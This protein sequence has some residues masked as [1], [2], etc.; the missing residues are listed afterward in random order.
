MEWI[1]ASKSPRRKQLLG[2]LIEKFDILPATG[3]EVCENATDSRS[4]VEALAAGKAR[5]V[6]ALPA[7]KGKA[8][9]GSDTVVVLDGEALGKPK[10]EADAKRMLRALS[11]RTHEVYTGVCISVP[12]A[13][14]RTELI[15]SDVTQVEFETL[16]DEA[17]AAYVA[18]GSP[19][20][21]A[22]AYGIQDGGLVRRITGSE[23]NVVGL[24]TELCAKMIKQ[25][26][27]YALKK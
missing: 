25:A 21:K 11:G 26:T 24:P 13:K 9:L 18:T 10:D 8:V 7:A 2:T 20:D 1:L 6:A 15:A 3:D 16:T 17:I 19:M 14:G 5:E 4:L 23:S 27:M 22:G 12:T